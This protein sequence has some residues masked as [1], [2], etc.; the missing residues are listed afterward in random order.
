MDSL[1]DLHAFTCIAEAQSLSGAAIVMGVTPSAVSKRLT[2]LERRLGVQLVHRTTRQFR[3]T[4]DGRVFFERCKEILARLRDAER[5]VVRGREEV[6]GTVR[7]A[8]AP[9]LVSLLLVPAL[10]RLMASWPQ[11]EVEF[12][13]SEAPINPLTQRIDVALFPGQ[14]QEVSLM[15]RLIGTT[16][17]VTVASPAYVSAFGAPRSPRDLEAHVA[18]LPSDPQPAFEWNFGDAFRDWPPPRRRL[19]A[20][21]PLVL[22]RM[23]TEGL[24]LARLPRRLIQALLADRALVPVLEPYTEGELSLYARYPPA[25]ATAPRVRA[26]LDWMASAFTGA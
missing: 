7:I 21:S 10:P 12:R 23:A 2:R 24:G 4:E 22:L 6:H 13:V 18:L 3:L 17:F 26:L 20:N 5:E 15:Q 9:E 8:A 16:P 14:P 11:L 1:L 19:F 25:D